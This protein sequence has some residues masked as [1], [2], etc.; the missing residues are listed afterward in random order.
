[1]GDPMGADSDVAGSSETSGSSAP[2]TEKRFRW[3]ADPVNLRGVVLV[4]GTGTGVGKTMVTAALATAGLRMDKRVAVVKPVQTG[5]QPKADFR[6]GEAVAEQSALQDHRLRPP[7]S[8]IANSALEGAAETALSSAQPSITAGAE[9]REAGDIAEVRRLLAPLPAEQLARLTTHEFVRLP[10][11]LAPQAAA[12]RAGRTLPS[13]QDHADRIV[14]IAATADLVLIEGAGGVLVRLD[15]DGPAGGTLADL[16]LLLAPHTDLTG[17]VVVTSAELGT[18]NVTELTVEALGR[19]GVPVI[20]LVIGRWPADPG[21]AEQDNL[22]DLPT[23]T[24]VPLLAGLRDDPVLPPS[25][26]RP[27]VL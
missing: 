13:L 21:P 12:L 4:T 10:D 23:L 8:K 16:A 7:L 27:D 24:G 26:R 20:G 19:R 15:G 1:M 3:V 9:P 25:L 11:P 5:T 6:Q 17:V 22:R 2:P 18:L 14:D